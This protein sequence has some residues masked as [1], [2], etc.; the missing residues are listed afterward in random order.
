[1]NCTLCEIGKVEES[2][3]SGLGA[4]LAALQQAIVLAAKSSRVQVRHDFMQR[5]PLARM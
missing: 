4:S 1:M 3:P 2:G 5:L